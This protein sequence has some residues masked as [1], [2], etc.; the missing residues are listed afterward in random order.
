MFDRY[1]PNGLQV[2]AFLD[3]LAELTDI[4]FAGI[5][6]LRANFT[7][8][9]WEMAFNKAGSLFPTR[10]EAVNAAIEDAEAIVK[11]RREGHQREIAK[12][13]AAVLVIADRL[14]FKEREVLYSAFARPL[15][16]DSDIIPRRRL[17][18][19]YKSEDRHLETFCELLSM[20]D[21]EEVYVESRPDNRGTTGEAL[22]DAII[23]RGK[24]TLYLEHTS[25]MSYKV[26]KANGKPD[27]M[28]SQKEYEKLW[29]CYIK[30]LEDEIKQQVEASCKGDLVHIWIPQNLFDLKID[31]KKTF[32]YSKQDLI[33][34]IV[35]AA[36]NTP[37]DDEKWSRYFKESISEALNKTGNKPKRPG[38]SEYMI[39]CVPAKRSSKYE[40]PITVSRYPY[41]T[42]C[43]IGQIVP[44]KQEDSFDLLKEDVGRAIMEKQVKLKAAK[45]RNPNATTV[46][47]L[48][49]DDYSFVNDLKLAKA[50]GSIA[51]YSNLDGIDEV[52]I[53]HEMSV[54]SKV[55]PVKLDN[56]Q[57]PDTEKPEFKQKGKVREFLDQNFPE[58]ED[59]YFRFGEK[60]CGLPTTE[61][62][63]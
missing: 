2:K 61:V 14:S 35:E 22:C 50:F 23:K 5:G 32:Y 33:S 25:L 39:S 7:I 48:V 9:D 46:L 59:Y 60:K 38:E 16:S 63:V 40:F 36:K 11:D 17:Y 34:Q 47:L 57:F 27:E 1:G 15:G 51:P 49:S 4:K 6:H 56:R 10:K 43:F 62:H 37:N 45:D 29:E 52:Y 30:P 28:R 20:I 54:A 44:M 19:K 42:I 55:L 24:K 18:E 8:E 21:D 26:P 12:G 13:I 53:Q 3:A 31:Y 58:Y 41:S